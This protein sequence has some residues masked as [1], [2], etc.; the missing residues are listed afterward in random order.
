MVIIVGTGSAEPSG[1]PP[2]HSEEALQ[3]ANLEDKNNTVTETEGPY[4]QSK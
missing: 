2:E 4:Q 3:E 1:K